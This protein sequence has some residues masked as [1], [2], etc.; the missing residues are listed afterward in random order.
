[1]ST[2]L[3]A[4]LHSV[5]PELKIDIGKI[6]GYTVDEIQKIERL[7]DIRVTGQLR[8]FLSC[9]GRCSGGFFGDDLLMFYRKIKSV[10]SHV[11]S[12]LT[13]RDDLCSLQH[14]ELV[15]KKPFL[16]SFENQTQYYFLLTE[17]DN[18]DLVYHYDENEDT[19]E[20][21]NWTF[22]EYLRNRVDTITRMHSDN[23]DLDYYGEL[24]II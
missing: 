1:M 15:A 8:E 10:R 2:T 21:T 18:P 22:H 6:K 17:S 12:Q 4:Y 19:V 16:I 3:I 13:L 23:R 20:A 24:I 9:M 11:L 5:Y 14:W 7:Y